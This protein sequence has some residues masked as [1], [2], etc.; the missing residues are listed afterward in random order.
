MATRKGPPDLRF[1]W[2]KRERDW[3]THFPRKPDGHL[4][5]SFFSEHGAP[6]PVTPGDDRPFVPLR[7]MNAREFFEELD[8][9]GYDLTTLRFSVRRR[10]GR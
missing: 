2:S 6:T 4:C 8:R 1:S 9:R 3:I 10:E 5:N 7:P